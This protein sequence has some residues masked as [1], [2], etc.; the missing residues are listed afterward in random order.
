M[1]P[2]RKPAAHVRQNAAR[3][4]SR[5]AVIV[6]PGPDDPSTNV[7]LPEP[8][9]RATRRHVETNVWRLATRRAPLH[10]ATGSSYP[11]TR[12]AATGRVLEVQPS[13]EQLESPS[14]T[15]PSD[16]S[17]GVHLLATQ[18]VE[19]GQHRLSLGFG[20]AGATID[21]QISSDAPTTPPLTT[22]SWSLGPKRQ[23]L[24]LKTFRERP[25]RW[26]STGS[27]VTPL[28]PFVEFDRDAA[29]TRVDAR[30]GLGD[31]G[32]WVHRFSVATT[33]LSRLEATGVD[34]I[35]TRRVSRRTWASM[36][37]NT[38]LRSSTEPGAG[39]Y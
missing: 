21:C 22:T 7:L 5:V 20:H 23:A 15:P 34:D 33:N 2:R 37:L 16:S 30:E 17:P 32:G 11:A 38:A 18:V 29:P 26:T 19:R 27:A 9:F 13:A 1:I 39:A 14:P 31:H 28:E 3:S 4:E 25:P 8:R 12:Q 35:T 24:L 36:L 6:V 10:G